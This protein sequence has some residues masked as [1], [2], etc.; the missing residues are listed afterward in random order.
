MLVGVIAVGPVT[1]AFFPENAE[2]TNAAQPTGA[3]I[4]P[5]I[6]VGRATIKNDVTLPAAVGAD[7]AAT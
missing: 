1:L 5:T 7:P 4:E 2:A 3:I 6:T